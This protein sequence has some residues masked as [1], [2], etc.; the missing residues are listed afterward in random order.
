MSKPSRRPGRAAR[1]IHER[2]REQ[3][4]T[5]RHDG[6]PGVRNAEDLPELAALIDAGRIAVGKGVPRSVVFEGRT[7]WLR[8]TFVA[9]LDIFGDPGAACPLARAVTFNHEEFGHAP[10]H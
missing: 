4:A 2:I 7:Y 5:L 8:V 9:H 10:G 1:D 3:A 6:A